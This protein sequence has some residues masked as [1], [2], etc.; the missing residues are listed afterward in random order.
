MW[1]YESFACMHMYYMC[2]SYPQRAPDPLDL[3]L[4]MVVSHHLAVRN[5]TQV[6]CNS[7]KCFYLLSHL[8]C[9]HSI[10]LSMFDPSLFFVVSV[11]IWAC[12]HTVIS[13]SYVKAKSFCL[14]WHFWRH[15]ILCHLGQFIPHSVNSVAV[16]S[17]P[18]FL[19]SLSFPLPQSKPLSE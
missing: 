19:S 13:S 18:F 2:T 17:L 15:H 12:L 11:K 3:Q 7:S 16:V 6:L 5:Q 1:V 9:S 10:F 14:D 4:R 8:S